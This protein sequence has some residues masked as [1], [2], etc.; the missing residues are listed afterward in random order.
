MTGH[1]KKI[2][3][4]GQV[5]LEAYIAESKMDEYVEAIHAME[6]FSTFTQEIMYGKILAGEFYKVEKNDASFVINEKIRRNGIIRAYN[7]K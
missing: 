5:D 2:N 6:K 4:P 3:E 7:I 1:L